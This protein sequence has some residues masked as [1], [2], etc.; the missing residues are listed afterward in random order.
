M[1]IIITYNLKD[2]DN[3]E[4]QDLIDNIVTVS[5]KMIVAKTLARQHS[6]TLLYMAK[7]L[8]L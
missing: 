1:D 3:V 5:V 7:S 4:D 8:I 2:S 6:T